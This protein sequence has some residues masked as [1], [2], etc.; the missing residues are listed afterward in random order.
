MTD[1]VKLFLGAYVN[2]TNA[3]NLNCLALAKHL[4]KSKF[5]ITTLS[6][7]SEPIVKIDGVTIFRCIWPHRIFVYWAYFWNIVKADV[8]Y[9][10][11]AEFLGFNS[12]ICLL[13]GKKS[14]STIEGILDVTATQSMVS[15]GGKNF[16]KYYHRLSRRYSI[17]RFMREYNHNKHNL[18]TQEQTLYLGT[19][20][21]QFLIS[22]KP[23][24]EL[25]NIIMIG[26]DLVRKGV[27]E[28]F[29][30]AN[31]Y[32]HLNFHLVGSG[33]GKIDIN[34]E[35]QNQNLKNVIY[36]GSISQVEL[37]SLL[38]NIQLHVFPSRSEGF[39]KV[40]L[41]TACAGVPSLVYS[42]YGAN[43]W[44]DHYRSGF[45]VNT[46]EEMKKVV[47][48]LQHNIN[49]LEEVSENTVRMGLSYDWKVKVK[50]WQD[51]MISLYEDK[52][53]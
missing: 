51:I 46:F 22:N 47:D 2:S 23:K 21:E 7:Y 34:K 43:E 31:M 17:T 11:K 25:R 33:N 6:L 49:L 16:V 53:S 10:P 28:F 30:L 50:P 9:L 35:I 24:S 20:S 3:Q 39:P 44:I 1:R 8:V 41:E 32:T 42:D 15:N 38:K 48:E 40:I 36:H 14:F 5:D 26:N 45:V 37:S 27:N 52:T 13:L 29:E 4:D 18:E 19:E 12:F